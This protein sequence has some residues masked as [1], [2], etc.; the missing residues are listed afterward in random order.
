MLIIYSI[1]NQTTFQHS[2]I[3]DK[4]AR[5]R[6]KFV[7]KS[8]VYME[9]I[10]IQV[11]SKYLV[12]QYNYYNYTLLCSTQRYNIFCELSSHQTGYKNFRRFVSKIINDDVLAFFI[13][14]WFAVQ[15][16][17]LNFISI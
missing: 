11:C 2:G 16:E 3:T 6:R 9:H 5:E 12:Y 14:L 1:Y 8:H 4:I 7:V 10:Y 13:F 15:K 17:I